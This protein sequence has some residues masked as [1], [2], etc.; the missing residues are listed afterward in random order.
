MAVPHD[1][2][3][4][5]RSGV[6]IAAGALAVLTTLMSCSVDGP[7]G[8]GSSTTASRHSRRALT[9]AGLEGLTTSAFT[10]PRCADGACRVYLQRSATARYGSWVTAHPLSL[11]LVSDVLSAGTCRVLRL[12]KP[13]GFICQ[14]IG[15]DVITR[16]TTQL[17]AAARRGACL[18]FT[19]SRPA[20]GSKL[21]LLDVSPSRSDRC[22]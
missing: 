13:V 17:T 8:P 19:L 4:R 14:L 16:I 10:G 6:M 18:R 9:Q 1:Q 5:A 11:R 15:G 2:G 7:G 22:S 20:R 21:R 12:A 3:T